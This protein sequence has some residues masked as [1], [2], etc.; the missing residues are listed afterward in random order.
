[1]SRVY[2]VESAPTLTGS[3]ADHRWPLKARDIERVARLLAAGLGEEVA[4]AGGGLPSGLPSAAFDAIIADLEEY[5]GRSL[6]IA[7]DGQP[8][9]VHALAHACNR[10]LGNIGKTVRYIE[11]V[12]ARP[13]DHL[14]SLGELVDDLKADR[15]RV[16]LIVG[17]NPV[18]NSP[19][20]LGFAEQLR[21]SLG[22][23]SDRSESPL[24]LC[25]H[26][27]DYYNETSLL[28][29]WHIPAAH[30]L[31]SWSD[32]RAFDGTATILQPLIAPLVRGQDGSRI[33]FGRGGGF[34]PARPTISCGNIGSRS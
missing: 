1:M 14:A 21:R 3:M 27:S 9:E 8:P 5:N 6:V 4:E 10:A 32:A 34:E 24:R 31:E 23:G 13:V 17:G 16:L 12:E 15:V 26:L 33:A 28:S 25:V 22:I 7:G 30:E 20:E 29:H 2:A 18:Y 19:A 11:P